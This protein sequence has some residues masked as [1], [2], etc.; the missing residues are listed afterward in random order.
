MK[1][2]P[3][4]PRLEWGLA[5]AGRA[6]GALAAALAG[7]A[8]GGGVPFVAIWDRNPE[9]AQRLA[10]RRGIWAAGNLKSLTRRCRVLLIAVSDDA[11]PGF[12][13]TLAEDLSA[14]GPGPECALH[15]AG[16]L[17]STVLAPLADRRK[18]ALGVFHPVAALQG[19]RSAGIFAGT[20]ATISGGP[21]ALNR[22]RALARHLGMRPL[23]VDDEA[24]ALVHLAAVLA[25]GD[26]ITLL[27]LGEELLERAGLTP[28]TSRKLLSTLSRSASSAYEEKGLE[29]ALT[30]PVPR[31][32]T[33]TL[34]R[35]LEAVERLGS[36]GMAIGQIHRRLA[37]E[38]ARR[39]RQ[40]QVLG[41]TAWR[42][43]RRLLS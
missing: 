23:V 18:M 14:S 4:T 39:L 32:D 16:A 20:Y 30:G 22:A 13:E 37:M 35:H 42:R 12:A 9:R 27:S 19:P 28:A 5:G 15:L 33:E 7:S 31:A 29:G 17:P 24:R 38:A 21:A 2:G 3:K 34:A 41:E 40:R 1:I 11:L 36:T 43:L 8:P 26:M 6:G 10:R 25:A